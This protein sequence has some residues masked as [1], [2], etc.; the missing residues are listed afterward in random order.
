MSLDNGTMGT[1]NW[2][3]NYGEIRN[4]EFD[5]LCSTSEKFSSKK[6]SCCY[7]RTLISPNVP[8]SVSNMYIFYQRSYKM[9]RSS[10]IRQ[11]EFRLGEFNTRLITFQLWKRNTT[12]QETRNSVTESTKYTTLEQ[13]RSRELKTA[14]LKIAQSA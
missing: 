12:E 1:K 5:K 4:V 13:P 8:L 9:T 6:K 14:M 10:H 3:R 11:S 2:K 7:T